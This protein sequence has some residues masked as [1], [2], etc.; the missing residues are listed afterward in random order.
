MDLQY[1]V[2]MTCSLAT[3]PT[4]NAGHSDYWRD[5]R[6][7]YRLIARAKVLF[8]RALQA[9]KYHGNASEDFDDLEDNL[10]PWYDFGDA[11]DAVIRNPT[12]I[13]ILNANPNHTSHNAFR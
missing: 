6:E 1:T 9:P 3:V 2:P 13:F 7:A 11:V 10:A 4:L 12:A 8:D 5:R